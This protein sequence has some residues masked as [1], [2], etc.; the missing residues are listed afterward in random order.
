VKSKLMYIDLLLPKRDTLNP[1]LNH[2]CSLYSQA[3][4]SFTFLRFK[5]FRDTERRVRNISFYVNNSLC[6]FMMPVDTI[7]SRDKTVI[8]SIS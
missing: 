5:R 2:K 1:Y 6:S 4:E 7:I 3:T 8:Y